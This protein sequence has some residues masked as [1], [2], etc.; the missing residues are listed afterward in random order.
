[1][2]LLLDTNVFL[3]IAIDEK[4]FPKHVERL[5]KKESSEILVSIVTPWEIALKSAQFGR[6]KLP[7]TAH[8]RLAVQAMGAR[9][10]PITMEH[11]DLLY[12]LPPHHADPFD[13][14]LI[15]QALAERCTLISSDQRFPPYVTAGLQLLWD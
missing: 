8:M 13:R 5:L 15:A 14:M 2:K 9:I 12:T 10:L 3:R 6:H 4:G 11:S 1:M 7:N